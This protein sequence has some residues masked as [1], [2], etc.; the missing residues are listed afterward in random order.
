MSCR[1]SIIASGPIHSYIFICYVPTI[2]GICI[3]RQIMFYCG[4]ISAH[5]QP[6]C[7]IM[8][9]HGVGG[10]YHHHNRGQFSAQRSQKHGSIKVKHPSA[11]LGYVHSHKPG[12]S[13]AE[14]ITS[15]SESR[16]SLVPRKSNLTYPIPLEQTVRTRTP[17]ARG[18]F[19]YMTTLLCTKL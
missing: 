15:P 5:A 17:P 9:R 6:S 8:A 14:G 16:K 4:H 10:D 3:S 12:P 19:T 7:G 11:I 1:S 13:F 2:D 18:L